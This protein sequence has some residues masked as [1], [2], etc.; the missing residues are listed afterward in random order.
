MKKTIDIC[1]GLNQDYRGVTLMKIF[2]YFHP[3]LFSLFL[4]IY[5]PI[6]MPSLINASLEKQDNKRVLVVNSYHPGYSWSDDI[7]LGIQDVLGTQRDVELII[8]HLDTKRHFEKPYFRQMEEL[9]RHKYRS[10]EIDLIITSD[11]NALDFILN[12]RKEL[13]PNAP[14][15][16]CGIDHI[17]P[18][19][20]ANQEYIY[21]I[22]EADSTSSTIKLILSIHPEIESITFIT[23]GTSTGQLML[24]KTKEL[25]P[26]F[27]NDVRFN[28]I[29]GVPVEELQLTLKSISENT[30]IFYLSFIRDKNGKVFSI[31]DSM[32][33]TAENANVPVYCS[34]GFQP[35]TGVIGGN[36]LSGYKQGEISAEIAGRLLGSDPVKGIP[37]IQQAPLVSKFD[38]KA[39]NR[40]N[41]DKSRTPQNSIVYNKP[42]SFYENYKT[43]IW[44][45]ISV[46]FTLVFLII[47][48]FINIEL[49][50]KTENDLQK[51]NEGLEQNVKDR[52]LE[53]TRVNKELEDELVERKQA[54]RALQESENTLSRMFSFADYMV[55]IADLKKGYFT[56]I[57]PAFTKH[58]GW[59]EKEMLSK[60]VIDFIHP[61]DLEKTTDIIKEQLEKG[62]DVIQF[63]NRYRTDKG[64]FRWFEWAANPVRE[65][66][67]T[68][69]AA[70]DITELKRAEELIKASLKEKEVLLKEIHH[71][72]KNNM[73][74]IISLLK[75]QSQNITDKQYLDMFKESQHRIK[76]MALVHEKLYRTKSLADIDFKGY[77]KSLVI[78]LFKSYKTTPGKITLNVDVGDVS[79][80]LERAIPCG[81]IINELVSNSLKYAFP[82]ERAGEIRVAF[83]STDEDVLVL[84]VSDN[85]IG[86]PEKLDF[87]NTE[88]LGLHLV[89]ILSEDQLHGTIELNRTNGTDFHIKLPWIST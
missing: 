52:T 86:M 72:V 85:G 20:I 17:K 65:E 26:A 89:T 84:E 69:S 71:R 61:D 29:I 74:V 34:W 30:I 4:L 35:G 81:L 2:K 7:M 39:L 55:C 23:D 33:L 31:E 63:E 60:P 45:T 22:E 27:Q 79:L 83:N 11:D 66:G 51:A 49:R 38:Y 14:L 28:Y 5:L 67:I 56:K 47:L 53:L 77:V 57:S 54:E 75:L 88:S 24:A 50:K 13:F 19:R 87:R 59:S 44:T 82:E 1:I 21:G 6:G 32:K 78:S 8:E 70:Y 10:S 18:E 16:F 43:I 41:I 46:G 42:D 68:Y 76:S 15:I 58:L 37:A 9:F 62:V 12:I 3:K 25:E 64:D 40:F 80:E 73:Q 36:V 48:L